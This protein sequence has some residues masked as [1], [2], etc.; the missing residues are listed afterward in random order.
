MT[1]SFINIGMLMGKYYA[2]E[3][4]EGFQL[5]DMQL[6]DLKLASEYLNDTM[7][8][9]LKEIHNRLP[10]LTNYR[11]ED[12]GKGVFVSFENRYDR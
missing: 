3:V 8:T 4:S 11:V 9:F 5:T 2:E 6:Y 10:Q 7:Q 12:F 1:A